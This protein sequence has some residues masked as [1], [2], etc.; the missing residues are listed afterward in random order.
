MAS[1]FGTWLPGDARGFRTRQCREHVEGDYRNPPPPGR[2]EK[3]HL[4]ARSRL[5][6]PPVVLTP[7]L[8]A[9]VL[10]EIVASLREHEVEVLAACVSSMHMHVLARFPRKPTFNERG[11]RRRTSAT[12]DPARHFIGIAKQWSSKQLI[13]A[14]LVAGPIWA[15]RGKIVAIADRAHQIN[16]FRYILNHASEGA[17]VWSFRDDDVT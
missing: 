3:R 7:A 10:A 5:S 6:R 12:D 15:K 9:R 13:R 16:V 14:G 1:T 4:A 17:A 8:R 11:L 2:Y